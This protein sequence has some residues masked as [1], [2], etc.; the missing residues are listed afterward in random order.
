MTENK[1]SDLLGLALSC[2][3]IKNT[4]VLELLFFFFL[5]D[6]LFIICFI[7]VVMCFLI[8]C[9]GMCFL[10]QEKFTPVPSV[11]KTKKRCV[12]MYNFAVENVISIVT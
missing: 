3:G 10:E 9:C 2:P 11:R 6:A 5:L 12:G 8:C 1:L 4:M 7:S